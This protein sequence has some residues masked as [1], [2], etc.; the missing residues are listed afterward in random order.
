MFKEVLQSVDSNTYYAIA[1]LVIFIGAFLA[2]LLWT[3]KLDNSLVEEM[4]SIP[5]SSNEMNAIAV[6]QTGTQRKDD[7]NT[8]ARVDAASKRQ[9]DKV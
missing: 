2:V 6:A 1:A 5:F 8:D 7:R 9:E 3:W 4:R